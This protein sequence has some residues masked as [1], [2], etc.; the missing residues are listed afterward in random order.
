MEFDRGAC[1]LLTAFF[2]RKTDTRILIT[3]RQRRPSA[4]ASQSGRSPT[5]ESPS[6]S[7]SPGCGRRSGSRS[8][9][10]S[11]SS[12]L[13][14]PPSSPVVAEALRFADPRTEGVLLES[15]AVLE[16]EPI[17]VR[18]PVKDVIHDCADD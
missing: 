6:S 18:L 4:G 1:D 3:V 9:S 10:A 5:D 17:A 16:R 14:F 7:C 12:S 15:I 11:R 2:L 13:L 8:S